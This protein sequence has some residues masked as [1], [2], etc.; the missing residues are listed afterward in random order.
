MDFMVLTAISRV[1]LNVPQSTVS[2][3]ANVHVSQD[4]G[5]K[6]VSLLVMDVVKMTFVTRKLDCA[7]LTVL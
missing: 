4:T 1:H 7:L 3:T 5:G 6:I 2:E